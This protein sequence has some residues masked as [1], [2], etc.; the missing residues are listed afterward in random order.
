MSDSL[1]PHG[2]YSPGNSPDQSTGVGSLSLLQQIFLTQESNQGLL[3]LGPCHLGKA[4]LCCCS[5]TKSCPT[6]CDPMDYNTPGF[7]SFTVSQSLFKFMSVASEMPSNHLILCHP[8]SFH[9]QSFL[10]SG[11]FPMSQFFASG[12]Q[13]IGVSATATDLP[14]N[15][16][17]CFPLGLPGWISL[18]SKGLSR[19]FS[20]T[21]IRKHRFFCIQPLGSA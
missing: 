15:I 16:Q 6:L 14:M 11:S 4:E 18:L 8:F 9:L 5:V 2:L 12:G 7:P 20:S 17:G 1:L 10:A 19:V 3:H 21:I 13:S